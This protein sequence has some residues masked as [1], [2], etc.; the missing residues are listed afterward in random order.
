MWN[1]N[2]ECHL[3]LIGDMKNKMEN[4]IENKVTNGILE[5]KQSTK[6]CGVHT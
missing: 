6:H 2:P 5:K 4:K 3:R 1:W